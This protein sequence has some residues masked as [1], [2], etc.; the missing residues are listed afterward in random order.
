VL[1]NQNLVVDYYNKL[2]V[3]MYDLFFN[4]SNYVQ[5]MSWK[6]KPTLNKNILFVSCTY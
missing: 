1:I 3:D 5:N 2:K 6:A 4:S